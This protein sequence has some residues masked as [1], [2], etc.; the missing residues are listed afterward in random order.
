MTTLGPST[1]VQRGRPLSQLLIMLALSII[2]PILVLTGSLIWQFARLDRGR[3]NHE[4]LQLARNISSQIDREIDGSIETLLA[5]S[6]SLTLQQ[7]DL[8]A[9][10]RQAR[11]TMDFRKLHVLLKMVDGQQ[12]V[13]T[14]VPWGTALPRQALSAADQQ[15]I[16][17]RQPA[18]SDLMIGVIAQRWVLGLSVPVLAGNEVRYLL[19]MSIDPE[20]L[21]RLIADVPREPKW[22]IAISD[23]TG[24]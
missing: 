2:I 13:N 14:R 15:V 18:I 10:Y 4:A 11:A 9:F 16:T 22:I 5:L 24:R 19:T 17:S 3:A 12:L 20:F 7:G 6:T 21:Q 23:R 1:P 8:E